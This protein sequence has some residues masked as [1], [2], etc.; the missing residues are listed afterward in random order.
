MHTA[1][2]S[3]KADIAFDVVFEVAAQSGECRRIEL[4]PG[5]HW[6]YRRGLAVTGGAAVCLKYRSSLFMVVI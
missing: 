4:I 1:K 5:G 3:L 2:K 6:E